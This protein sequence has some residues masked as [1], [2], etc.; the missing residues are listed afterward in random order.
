MSASSHSA[1]P[2]AAAIA[3]AAPRLAV[4]PT[5]QRKLDRF[6]R[7]DAAL[8]IHSTGVYEPARA[9]WS[10]SCEAIPHTVISMGKGIYGQAITFST[11]EPRQV[12]I[13]RSIAANPIGDKRYSKRC[14]R[15]ATAVEQRQAEKDRLAIDGGLRAATEYSNRLCDIVADAEWA[16]FKMPAASISELLVKIEIMVE[17][18][19]F[20]CDDAKT[21][22]L[23]DV[24]AL[25]GA[26]A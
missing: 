9:R 25:N 2:R 6:R 26:D 15:L 1:M 14:A 24:R 10:A 12:A 8:L 4:R 7:L 20:T 18:D 17:R 5:F 22:I 13:A 23:A 3:P 21:A 19:A 11:A 16:F